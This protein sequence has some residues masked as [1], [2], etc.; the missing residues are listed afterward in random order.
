MSLLATSI[1]PRANLPQSIPSPTLWAAPDKVHGRHGMTWEWISSAVSVRLVS[2]HPTYRVMI[3]HDGSWHIWHLCIQDS[4]M[5]QSLSLAPIIFQVLVPKNWRSILGLEDLE[6]D[7]ISNL[8]LR[9]SL[10][11]A[12]RISG[13]V[14]TAYVEPLDHQRL[15]FAVGKLLVMEEDVPIELFEPRRTMYGTPWIATY[16]YY[17]TVHG[18]MAVNDCLY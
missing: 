14:C 3:C 4:S 12:P 15:G 2:L 9:Q 18:H 10:A 16:R 1:S 13:W 7:Q 11:D 8:T 5:Y 17:H 6:P